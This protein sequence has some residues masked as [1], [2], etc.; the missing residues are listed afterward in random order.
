MSP[1]VRTQRGTDVRRRKRRLPG[2][3]AP[4]EEMRKREKTH[5]KKDAERR[6]VKA[7]VYIYSQQRMRNPKNAQSI[8]TG[9][10][11]RRVM[12]ESKT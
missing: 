12:R 8:N 10:K 5:K 9:E 3:E 4:G 2:H 7:S 1:E 6:V 11:G